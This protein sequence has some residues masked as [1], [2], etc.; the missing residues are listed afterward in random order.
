MVS[1]ILIHIFFNVHR[2]W[3]L[4]SLPAQKSSTISLLGLNQLHWL[5]ISFR[6]DFKILLLTY[7][8]LN[9][10]ALQ[11]LADLVHIEVHSASFT[12]TTNYS[13]KGNDENSLWMVAITFHQLQ[14]L[15]ELFTT[16]F[17]SSLYVNIFKRRLKL[18]SKAYIQPTGCL[19]K[20]RNPT[21]ALYS[22]KHK[23]WTI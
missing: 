17:K 6:I 5:P 3:L 14:V 18:F 7:K 23:R 16:G 9:G 10:L 8:V 19:K 11:Y 20:K 4:K 13:L 12:E 15:M 21:S 2:I 22:M 1:Q